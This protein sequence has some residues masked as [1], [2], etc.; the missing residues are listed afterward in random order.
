MQSKAH[1]AAK[2]AFFTAYRGWLLTKGWCGAAP[3]IVTNRR[4]YDGKMV[5]VWSAGVMLYVMLFC[6]YPFERPEDER[7]T[8]TKKYQTVCSSLLFRHAKLSC[9]DVIAAL[10]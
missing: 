5:D 7:E 10:F 6:T 1:S 9:L 3:E 2:G 4:N 8:P